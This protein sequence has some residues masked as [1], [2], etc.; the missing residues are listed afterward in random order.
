MN[1][2]D[3]ASCP[4][5]RGRMRVMSSRRSAGSVLTRYRQ[6]PRCS[7]RTVDRSLV[8]VTPIG[9]PRVLGKTRVPESAD[10]A[11]SAASAI[12]SSALVG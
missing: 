8:T 3:P 11:D 4:E 5:C 2:I 6:C 7:T 10:L 1:D 9:S 12:P